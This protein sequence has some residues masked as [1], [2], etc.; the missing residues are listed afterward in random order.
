MKIREKETVKQHYGAIA[1]QTSSKNSCCGVDCC[2][3]EDFNVAESYQT[4]EGYIEEADLGLGCG[5]PTDHA[6]INE[7]DTVVDLG[8]GAGNDAFVARRIVGA[9]GHV[10]GIDFTPAMLNRARNNAATLGYHNVEFLL[11]DIENIPLKDNLADVIVSNCVINL[12]PDKARAFREIY[13]I[14][15]PG[16]RFSIS[17][18]VLTTTLPPRLKEVAELY[19]GCISGATTADHYMKLLQESGFVS[20]AIKKERDITIPEELIDKYLTADER[21]TINLSETWIKSITF[22]GTKPL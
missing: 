10:Y 16:G 15:K 2:Q 17:D 5:I 20:A 12:V 11:G 22:V 13:R 7:G 9:E 3:T 8:S 14:L 4:V 18:M 1:N 19:A 21:A 6:L